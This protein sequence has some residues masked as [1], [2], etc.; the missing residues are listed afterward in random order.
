VVECRRYG[1]GSNYI[2]ANLGQERNVSLAR[3]LVRE[4][5]DGIAGAGACGILLVIDSPDDE[6][7][8]ICLVEEA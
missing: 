5:V 3:G 2:C 1:V 8:A 6:L 4:G 7:G